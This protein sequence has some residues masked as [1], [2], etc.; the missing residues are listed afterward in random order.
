MVFLCHASLYAY[1]G[2]NLRVPSHF[3]ESTEEF[4]RRGELVNSNGETFDDVWKRL[5]QEDFISPIEDPRMFL[6]DPEEQELAD[7]YS[8]MSL[9]E[10]ETVLVDLVDRRIISQSSV[11]VAESPLRAFIDILST[12]QLSLAHHIRDP[13]GLTRVQKQLI[14]MAGENEESSADIL[15]SYRYKAFMREICIRWST[16]AT[17]EVEETATADT[18]EFPKGPWGYAGGGTWAYPTAGDSVGS[19][20]KVTFLGIVRREFAQQIREG[21]PM[22]LLDVGTGVDVVF[23][24]KVKK[25]FDDSGIIAEVHG[26]GLKLYDREGVT[27]TQGPVQSFLRK[28]EERG[29]YNIIT[30]NAPTFIFNV[31]QFFEIMDYLLAPDGIIIVQPPKDRTIGREDEDAGVWIRN[32]LIAELE[33]TG[34]WDIQDIPFY[35]EDLPKGRF[36]VLPPVLIRRISRPELTTDSPATSPE[37]DTLP[38]EVQSPTRRAED[39][40][41]HD[42]GA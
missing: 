18:P 30:I 4:N 3:A 34:I 26:V 24:P 13:L 32:E 21:R 36:P 33:A 38:E 17:S 25:L 27:L 29:K 39:A 2:D 40:L 15:D 16:G 7:Q 11:L 5:R 12:H 37:I 31:K 10:L 6:I 22:R 42:D 41:V 23:P 14:E 20:E 35:I 9:E 8:S 28:D 19:E 1:S